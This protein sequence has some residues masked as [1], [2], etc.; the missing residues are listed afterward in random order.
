MFRILIFLISILSALKTDQPQ[1]C[2]SITTRIG[3]TPVL[4]YLTVRVEEKF[5][6]KLQNKCGQNWAKM[7]ENFTSSRFGGVPQCLNSFG[8]I[9][10]KII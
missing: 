5:H 9:S 2:F 1:T 6:I 8:C 10:Y 7:S 3:I 4:D